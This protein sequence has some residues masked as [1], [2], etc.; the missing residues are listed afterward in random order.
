MKFSS[1]TALALAAVHSAFFI[2]HSPLAMAASAAAASSLSQG[3]I[4]AALRAAFVQ[5]ELFTQSSA[6]E[7]PPR[8]QRTANTAGHLVAPDLVIA[9]DFNMP[10]RFVREW[11]VAH[12]MGAGVTARPIAW[13]ADRGAMLLKLDNPLSGAR[14]LEFVP[15]E[16]A[17]A[18]ALDT[19]FSVKHA[20]GADRDTTIEPLSPPRWYSYPGGRRARPLPAGALI[21]TDAGAPV[22]LALSDPLRADD[23]TLKIPWRE[24]RWIYEDDLAARH[25]KLA[26]AAAAA[27]LLADITL[28]PL[29]ARAGETS[30]RSTI[31]DPSAK[32]HPAIVL[33]PRRV[34]VLAYMAPTETARLENTTLRLPGGGAVDARFVATV[35]NRG[36]FVVEP[37]REIDAPLAFPAKRLDWLDRRQRLLLTIDLRLQGETLLARP[38]ITR[39]LS[40]D[41][42]T[43]PP[44]PLNTVPRPADSS[45]S[46]HLFDLDGGFLGG[47]LHP[48]LKDG[49]L[50]N[51]TNI[52]SA[53]TLATYA[54]NYRG[55]VD[56]LNIPRDEA[57]ER[58]L[59]WLGVDLQPLTRELA[60]AQGVS[61]RTQN[62]ATGGLV[63]IVH[64][65][66]PAERARLQTGDVLLRMRPVNSRRYI[67]IRPSSHNAS[68]MQM[69]TGAAE[70][71]DSIYDRIP[72]PWP[73][74]DSPL[75]QTLKRIGAG[76]TFELEYARDGEFFTVKFGA[77]EG[78]PYYGNA[79]EAVIAS[80][81]LNVK[82]LTF[83]TRAFYKI[84][85]ADSALIV[86]RVVAGG[87]ASI[88]GLRP[89]D[90]ITEVND[91]PV[92][93]PAAFSEL[94]KTGGKLRLLTRRISQ[95]RIVTLDTE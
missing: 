15:A 93:T 81:G 51:Y 82:T 29:P 91:Q 2:S 20:A 47:S 75:N 27:F 35:Q 16:D 25:E 36:A 10:P 71:P 68:A 58:R 78:P 60:Q 62:G 19:C 26:A 77:R 70:I 92:T 30:P 64:P 80:I 57:G 17:A 74:A 7:N 22:A 65:G 46:L 79:P 86:S 61:E 33:S 37:A 63:T 95:T 40:T 48:R 13:A 31:A 87:R 11:R 12:G 24:W 55:W 66:S 49:T 1:T 4:P 50:A 18:I 56:P 52:E 67:A 8:G 72:T 88:A 83:E 5:V 41:Y 32:P 38:G 85:D 42:S 21:V 3:E 54:G 73:S 45:G 69:L 23:D 28:R 34:L 59:V 89:Y 94:A 90:L 44:N 43:I 53:F 76:K 6:G 9:P 84:P 39:I 14:P